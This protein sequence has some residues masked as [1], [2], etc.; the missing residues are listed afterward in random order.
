VS[1]TCAALNCTNLLV[2]R[3]KKWCSTHRKAAGRTRANVDT[4]P[5]NVDTVEGSREPTFRLI[6]EATGSKG[7]EAIELMA[8]AGFDLDP[9]QRDTLIAAMG[10]SEDRWAADDVVVVQPRQNG[11]SA[12]LVARAL[13]GVTLGGE[14]LALFSA[15][16]FKTCREAFLLA[17][18]LCETS[19]LQ[20]FSPRVAIAH[21]KEGIEFA[22]G[23]RLLFIARTR[24]SGRG[25]SP[26]LV[27]ADEAFELDDLAL[28]ALKP[29]MAAAKTPQMWFASSAPHET[30]S[31]LRRLCLKGRG[32]EASRLCYFEWAADADAPIEDVRAWIQ[33]NPGIG[34]RIALG[35]IAAE[36]GTMEPDD[37]ARERLGI[38]A[39]DAAASVFPTWADLAEENPPAPT[40]ARALGIDVTPDRRRACIAA[41]ADIGEDRVLVEILEE[42][43]GVS[44]VVDEVAALVADHEPDAV[45]VDMR[46]QARSLIAA[47]EKAGVDVTRTDWAAMTA[48][49]GGFHDAVVEGRLVHRDDPKLNAAVEGAVQRYSGDA[50]AW[51]RRSSRSNVSPLVAVTLAAWGVNET[52]PAVPLVAWR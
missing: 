22:T 5:P 20:A 51:A 16:E 32:G 14:R 42:R 52:E 47:L 7:L 30:S 19:A 6:P 29:S 39:E 27:I 3:Q 23:G 21:G 25:F 15:H 11:K 45:V 44:W 37:F 24:T 36:L 26:D 17:R 4:S 10:V 46:G 49:C 38:W 50:W 8:S 1:K 35:T 31:V 41:A 9:P 13:W 28:S 12:L 33:A 43:E 2:G 18:S 34:R 40:G 48:A